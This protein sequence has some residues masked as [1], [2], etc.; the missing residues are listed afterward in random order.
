M[1]TKERISPLSSI[2][3][4]LVKTLGIEK[5]VEQYKIFDAW[6]SIVGEQ[7]SK[8]AQPERFQNGTLFVSVNNAPWR[9]E[10][11]YRKKD[12]LEK[13][14]ASLHSHSITDIRFR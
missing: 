3:D 2:I 4:S 5:Q 6:N 9:A 13:I 7:I 10:L 1:N 11:T 14:H 8:V 12:L